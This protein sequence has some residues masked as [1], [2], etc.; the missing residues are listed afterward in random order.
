MN[1]ELAYKR[2]NLWL[3]PGCRKVWVYF[4]D[5]KQTPAYSQLPVSCNC[6][7]KK[8]RLSKREQAKI[9]DLVIKSKVSYQ[10]RPKI[11]PKSYLAQCSFCNGKIIGKQ[12]DKGVK[13]RNQLRF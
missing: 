7:W 3:C 11:G 1:C 5:T 12:K 10:S 9:A 2:L 4:L 6:G 13:N 8:K